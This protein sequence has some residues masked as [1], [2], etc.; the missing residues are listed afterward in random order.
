MC[1]YDRC[2]GGALAS[3]LRSIH[4]GAVPDT[5]ARLHEAVTSLRAHLDGEVG[6]L[7]ARTHEAVDLAVWGGQAHMPVEVMAGYRDLASH[8]DAFQAMYHQQN[9]AHLEQLQ[10]LGR[11][12]EELRDEV[13]ILR[14]VTERQRRTSQS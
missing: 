3:T 5:E 11:S 1:P 4:R 12:Q 9:A 14:L 2:G 13:T 7:R 10:M 6:S 8:L